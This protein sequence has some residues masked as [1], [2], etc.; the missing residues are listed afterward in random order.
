MNP[1]IA[2]IASNRGRVATCNEIMDIRVNHK[3]HKGSKVK[4]QPSS[5][6]KQQSS[7]LST[8]HSHQQQPHRFNK[9]KKSQVGSSSSSV[10]GGNRVFQ[11]QLEE[12]ENFLRSFQSAGGGV[13][14]TGEGTKCLEKAFLAAC[15]DGRVELAKYVLRKGLSP[16]KIM[17]RID[18]PV[19]LAA[20]GGNKNLVDLLVSEGANIEELNEDGYTPLMEAVR[21]VIISN[22]DIGYLLDC[23]A[24]VNSIS[25]RNHNHTAL[26]LACRQG[27]PEL[28]ALL[29]N[30]GADPNL[31]DRYPMIEAI[32]NNRSD[33]VKLLV[34]SGHPVNVSQDKPDT[35]LGI[36][37]E[38]GNMEIVQYLLD[39]GALIELVDCESGLTP[40]M[41][42]VVADRVDLCDLLL[43]RG[44]KI[45]NLSTG[46]DHSA[47]S[48][49]VSRGNQSVVRFLLANGADPEIK[50]RDGANCLMEACKTGNLEIAKLLICEVARRNGQADLK[51]DSGT[52]LPNDRPASTQSVSPTVTPPSPTPACFQ[53]ALSAENDE[54]VRAIGMHLVEQINR[55]AQNEPGCA[56][57]GPHGPGKLWA[58]QYFEFC[59]KTM[60]DQGGVLSSAH[61]AELDPHLWTTRRSLM[62]SAPIADLKLLC[63]QEHL[64]NRWVN[65]LSNC[66]IDPSNAAA[67]MAAAVANVAT[68]TNSAL[69]DDMSSGDEYDDEDEDEDDEGTTDNS[70]YN[71]SDDEE[72]SR[73]FDDKLGTHTAVNTD[74]RK[75]IE[76]VREMAKR[77]P[78]MTYHSEPTTH[79]PPAC[80]CQLLANRSY[81]TANKSATGRSRRLADHRSPKLRS[82]PC[83]CQRKK[84]ASAKRTPQK[85]QA[86]PPTGITPPVT[87]VGAGPLAAHV[88]APMCS[89]GETALIMAA[90]AGQPDIVCALLTAGAGVEQR[91]KAGQTPLMVASIEGNL[92]VAEVLLEGGA[93]VDSMCDK[94]RDT[95]LS[96]ACSHGRL[97]LARLMLAKGASREHRNSSDYTPMC[98]AATSGHVDII[99]LLAQ[100]KAEIDSR[101]NSKLGITPLMLASMNG[102]ALAVQLLL[103]LGADINA[104]VESNRNTA[105]TLACYQGR[106]EVVKVLVKHKATIDHRSKSGLTPLMEA[107]SGN[108]VDIGNHLIE[109]GADVNIAPPPQSRDTALTIAADRGH[110]QFVKLLVNRGANIEAR[111]KRGQTPLWLACNGGHLE[112]VK[113][114]LSHRADPDSEDVRK[115][116]CLKAAFQQGH[117]AV[118]NEMV[119]KVKQYPL[120]QDMKKFIANLKSTPAR[121]TQA[122]S[123]SSVHHSMASQISSSSAGTAPNAAVPPTA[124][125]TKQPS[126]IT[127]AD[128]RAMEKRCTE[129]MEA[130]LA[131]KRK[132]TLTADQ[133]ANEL[134]QMIEGEE[135]KKKARRDAAIRRREKRKQ[136]RNKKKRTEVDEDYSKQAASENEDED[137]C[138]QVVEV[139][140]HVPV[141]KSRTPSPEPQGNDS[142]SSDGW[143]EAGPKRHIPEQVEAPKTKQSVPPPLRQQ[144]PPPLPLVQPSAQATQSQSTS[145]AEQPPRRPSVPVHRSTFRPSSRAT[146]TRRRWGEPRVNYEETPQTSQQRFEPRQHIYT[147]TSKQ[148]VGEEMDTPAMDDK[149]VFPELRPVTDTLTRTN[150]TRPPIQGG[151][152]PSRGAPNTWIN[153]S[154]SRN[155]QKTQSVT[156]NTPVQ[157]HHVVMD[158]SKEPLKAPSSVPVSSSNIIPPPIVPITTEPAKDVF[159]Q[160]EEDSK[161]VPI[162]D[163]AFSGSVVSEVDMAKAPGYNRKVAQ[164][165]Q[166]QPVRPIATFLEETEQTIPQSQPIGPTATN[167]YHLHHHHHF[168]HM[169]TGSTSAAA[170]AAAGSSIPAVEG[171]EFE[172]IQAQQQPQQHSPNQQNSLSSGILGRLRSLRLDAPENRRRSTYAQPSVLGEQPYAPYLRRA[173]PQ[174]YS[175]N[176]DMMAAAA[177]AAVVAVASTTGQSNSTLVPPP[178]Q[179]IDYSRTASPTRPLGVQIQE[180]TI[181]PEHWMRTAALVGAT[182]ERNFCPQNE[183]T[184]CVAAAA[185]AAAAAYNALIGSGGSA[186]H[187]PSIFAASSSGSSDQS[188][189]SVPNAFNTIRS[190]YEP[191]HHNHQ[192]PP[193]Q[194]QQPYTPPDLHRYFPDGLPFPFRQTVTSNQNDALP[195]SFVVTNNDEQGL[196][197][198]IT[199]TSGRHEQPDGRQHL[200]HPPWYT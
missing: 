150:Q 76:M 81:S 163:L 160:E 35:P 30:K 40:L 79:H 75:G 134:L 97:D 96:Y 171:P 37:A 84:V 33:I 184:S 103:E 48:L 26:S 94:T 88:N 156:I 101:T 183:P 143:K 142:S 70:T 25:I 38:R 109:H 36:A 56:S 49:A 68:A 129:A 189:A 23:K 192:Q 3:G 16:D 52:K 32:E 187:P 112:T 66:K 123:L 138:E 5:S 105:L 186:P 121:S 46:E 21:Q 165:R 91:N 132:Q 120:E 126:M 176:P 135:N 51:I 59:K 152:Q 113:C 168:H 196:M 53:P 191:H 57:C 190:Y 13:H 119:G 141:N 39:H 188:T 11:D 169:H 136:K 116:S 44:A 9:K 6:Q 106:F 83:G 154:F 193:P 145:I 71:V 118:V 95:P 159:G 10:V 45:D 104:H 99:N 19:M 34:E 63:E 131:A 108:F 12:F 137:E 55:M 93:Q 78:P 15:M 161:R 198:N 162:S 20:L 128:F 172:Y 178:S 124:F 146:F 125:G 90:R 167:Q 200:D 7:Q 89:S 144:S 47:L 175:N 73:F 194:Q 100:H 177:A 98:L 157:A 181:R 85:K 54:R 2:T 67:V 117:S 148:V 155:K 24:D 65:H 77:S 27:P 158:S 107:A 31:T 140:K 111:N 4:A 110:H 166:Q 199:E 87:E 14:G 17:E 170:A 74:P 153:S 114:L 69:V 72:D 41:R 1:R 149:T 58:E 173:L 130:I 61:N 102:H 29:L 8:N 60:L 182:D 195:D 62:E 22:G 139:E 115:V 127:E 174:T 133:N 18:T 86:Q 180:E 43:R 28:I 185:A 197:G 147:R 82:P 64:A 151:K 164:R 42:A 122:R 92:H 179:S 80:Q 50:L